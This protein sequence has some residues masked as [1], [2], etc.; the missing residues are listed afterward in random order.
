MVFQGSCAWLEEVSGVCTDPAGGGTF[1]GA[2]KL[3]LA[4]FDG[5]D[6]NMVT[7]WQLCLVDAATGALRGPVYTCAYEDFDCQGA[8]GTVMTKADNGG[9]CTSWPETVVIYRCG[10]APG[11]PDPCDSCVFNET[12]F[13]NGAGRR[14]CVPCGDVSEIQA[15]LGCGSGDPCYANGCWVFDLDEDGDVDFTDLGQWNILCNQ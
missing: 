15:C 3:S 4:C 10:E 1:G 12:C 14:W 9:P 13:D 8:G 11:P 2:W 6:G 5:G 7:E